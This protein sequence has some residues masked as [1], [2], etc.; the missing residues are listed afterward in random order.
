MAELHASRTQQRTAIIERVTRPMAEKVSEGPSEAE[1]VDAKGPVIFD[2]HGSV[3]FH[4]RRLIRHRHHSAARM[5]TQ[6]RNVKLCA[7]TNVSRETLT[8]RR[9]LTSTIGARRR[10]SRRR[11][12]GRCRHGRTRLE[13]RRALCAHRLEL[14]SD[15]TAGT[16][17]AGSAPAQCAKDNGPD[18]ARFCWRC[19]RCMPRR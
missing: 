12:N 1:A 17:P 2:K 18:R 3:S 14:P 9:R 16:M 7:R 8:A 5:E 4:C 19:Y 13:R 11:L 6:E 10:I 15:Q